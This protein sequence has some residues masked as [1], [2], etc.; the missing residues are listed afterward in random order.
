MQ[1]ANRGGSHSSVHGSALV[2]PLWLFL[3]RLY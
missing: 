2:L 1:S 3:V